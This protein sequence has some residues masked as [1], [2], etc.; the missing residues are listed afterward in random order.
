MGLQL[1]LFEPPPPKKY[2]LFED[3]L[4]IPA[5]TLW[6]PYAGAVLLAALGYPGKEIETRT[7]TTTH[8]GEFVIAAGLEMDPIVFVRVRAELIARGIPADV[9]DH[10]LG[11][12]G[13]A[14]VVARIADC[15]PLTEADLRKSFV[16]KAGEKRHAWMLADMCPLAPFKVT[17]MPGFFGVPKADVDAARRKPDLWRATPL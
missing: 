7:F 16:W 11:L 8:R 15:R 1:D 3:P 2:S 14:L 9:V 6:Q 4:V 13:V 17:G 12:V 5:R 10:A